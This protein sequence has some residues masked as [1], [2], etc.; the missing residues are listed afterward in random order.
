MVH[1]YGNEC[2]L[3]TLGDLK[4]RVRKFR[5]WSQPF[6]VVA[7][8]LEQYGWMLVSDDDRKA[9]GHAH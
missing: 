2:G 8:K 5:L 9:V 3:L 4:P 6:G 1:E 7:A